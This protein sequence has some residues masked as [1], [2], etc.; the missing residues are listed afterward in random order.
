MN[1]IVT[2][3]KFY[4]NPLTG[5]RKK[6]C[7]KSFTSRDIRFDVLD[8]HSRGQYP[9]NILSNFSSTDFTFDGIKIKS[10]EGFLQSL[11]VKNIA[12]QEKLCALNGFEAKKASKSIK[13]NKED[14]LLFWNGQSFRRDSQQY[15]NL[16]KQVIELQEKNRNT[17][18]E[19]GSM[20]ISSVN[21][22]LLALKVQDPIRQKEL[23]VLP[24]DKI[25]EAS[26]SIE[27]IYDARILYWKGKPIERTS[28]EYSELLDKVYNIRFR[29]DINYRKA[30][31]FSK[32]FKNIIHSIGKQ[33]VADTILTEKEFISH[34][35]KLQKKDNYLY[36]IFDVMF[37]CR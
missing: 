26:K 2:Q 4:I 13:R 7:Q 5:I 14:M 37:K 19:L 28:K 30:I 32:Q 21:A 3:N 34:I 10:I 8:I 11:K 22:F 29:K 17:S 6:N 18:F 33:N 24:L 25:K 36:K 20:K 35:K 31:R 12:Q 9:A 1:N 16:L 23:S 15:K 27:P